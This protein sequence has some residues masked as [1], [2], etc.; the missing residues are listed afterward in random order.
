MALDLDAWDGE[1][2][3]IFGERAGPY[4]HFVPQAIRRY[5]E[6]DL[7]HAGLSVSWSG[8]LMAQLDRCA[9]S[10]R[11]GGQ[12]ADWQNALRQAAPLLPA[13]IKMI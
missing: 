10:G 8:T 12:F 11:V 9:E 1:K 2:E 3:S 6:G 13:W 4:T 5:V 7:P